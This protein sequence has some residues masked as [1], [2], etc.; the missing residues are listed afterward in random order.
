MVLAIA[1]EFDWEALQFD[2]KTAFPQSKVDEVYVK[3]APGYEVLDKK[4][5]P[6]VVRLKR[7]I[8]WVET[9]PS[10]LGQ[11]VQRSNAGYWIQAVGK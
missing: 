8:L 1:T 9:A 3:Y 4:G 6:L 11:D 7:Y 2:I 10:G 5:F